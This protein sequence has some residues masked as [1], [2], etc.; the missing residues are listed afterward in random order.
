MSIFSR[1][2]TLCVMLLI[3]ATGFAQEAK[4]LT[5]ATPLNAEKKIDVVEFFWY[6]CGYCYQLE[7]YIEKWEQNLPDNVNFMKVPAFT[8]GLWD[9]HGRMY[10]TLETM[11]LPKSIHKKVFDTFHKEKNYMQNEKE[12]NKFLD[13]QN[14][15]KEQ[16]FKIYN[17]AGIKIQEDKARSLIRSYK[18]T[19]VPVVVVAGKHFVSVDNGNEAML[20]QIDELIAKETSK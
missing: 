3:S 2:I 15:D 1:T 10:L 5:P 9:I 16:F 14:I 18:I 12:I 19:G 11:G 7:P 20:Q 4:T 13:A 17:S 6:G 8:G